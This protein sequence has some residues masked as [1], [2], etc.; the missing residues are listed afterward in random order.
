MRKLLLI[1]LISTITIFTFAGNAFAYRTVDDVVTN[2]LNVRSGPS[3]SYS[4]IAQVVL[5]EDLISAL[6]SY[7]VSADGYH[8][9]KNLYPVAS[10]GQYTESIKGWSANHTE[11]TPYVW[12]YKS[13]GGVRVTKSS[14]IYEYQY[15]NLTS[16]LPSEEFPMLY[17]YGQNIGKWDTGVGLRAEDDYPN[18]WRVYRLDG[19]YD[20]G[21]ANGW[22]V[23]AIAQ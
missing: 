9:G 11:T 5:G 2:N 23:T 4:V 18:G 14:G 17:N 1:G 6:D 8:W 10:A 13:S 12:Y 22:H 16:A 21:Y 15:P 20:L 19:S 3:V 7:T